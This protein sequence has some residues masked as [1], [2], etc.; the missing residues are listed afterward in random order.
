MAVMKRRSLIVFAL[1]LAAF[2]LP[3]APPVGAQENI[4]LQI[5]TLVPRGSAW[6]RVFDAWNNT[7]RQQTGNRLSLRFIPPGAQ[8]DE[9]SIVQKVRTGELDGASIT[10]TGLG[11][12]VRPALVLQAPAVFDDYAQLDRARTTMHDEFAHQ[13]EENGVKLL[14]WADLGQG[15][16]FSVRRVERP[17]DLRGMHPW[18]YRDDSMFSEFLGV[19]GATGVRLGIPEVL[20]ALGSNRIDVVVASATAASALQ[21]HTRVHFVTQQPNAL[22]I[23]ATVLSKSRFDSLPP[24]LQ[25]ALTSTAT[26]AHEAL[27]RRVRQD[28]DRYYQA[29]TTRQGLTATDIRAHDNEWRQ[30]A[31]Q[32]RTRLAGRLFTRELLDRTM[33]AARG[34]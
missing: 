2:L 30:A 32:T 21:W 12:V 13:F 20:P 28:D 31:E 22:L 18:I 8:G 33:R 1:A 16:I 24:D 10:S 23:G 11:L 5:A 25:A 7:L 26:R 4:T 34:Q 17:S 6:M 9:R 14:G 3:G 29:L 27:L 19:I 15:R